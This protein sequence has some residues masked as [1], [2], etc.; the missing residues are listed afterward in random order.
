MR[1]ST[2]FLAIALLAFNLPAHA[3]RQMDSAEVLGGKLTR[4]TSLHVH[5]FDTTNTYL[6]DPKYR[7]TAQAMAKSAPHL[8]AAD[9]VH[10][11]RE[12][13]FTGVTLDES[14]QGPSAEGLNLTGRFTSLDPGSQ[15]L[16]VWI[17]FGAGESKVCIE[18][19]VS[20]A[21]GAKLATFSDCRKGLGWGESGKQ[22]QKGAV[23]LGERLANFLIEWAD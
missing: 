9:V 3:E 17:G 4:D 5:L 11:L 10:A 19:E 21:A 2:F 7:D 20:D 23:I 18:G 16:R 1:I 13:G 22:G 12:A 15:G 14:E 8:L 6:G